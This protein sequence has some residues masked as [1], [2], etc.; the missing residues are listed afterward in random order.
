M[1]LPHAAFWFVLAALAVANGL[2]REATYGA[3]LHELRAHQVSTLALAAATALVS[4]P[5]FRVFPLAGYA[6][7]L[8][9]GALWCAATVAFEFTFGRLVA[10]KDFARLLHDYDLRAGRVWPLFLA[11]LTALPVIA[12]FL[13]ARA[14]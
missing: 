14:G 13:A 3:R 1:T 6:E 4:W 8:A 10:R 9:L 11:W 7:A 2:L 5:F 12:H